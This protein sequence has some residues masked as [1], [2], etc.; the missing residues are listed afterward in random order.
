MARDKPVIAQN[1]FK[2]AAAYFER[3]LPYPGSKNAVAE[4][5]DL[6]W[7]LASQT[8][9][10]PP[11]DFWEGIGIPKELAPYVHVIMHL[12][13]IDLLSMASGVSQ[14]VCAM[15]YYKKLNRKAKV[16][17]DELLGDPRHFAGH[18]WLKLKRAAAEHHSLPYLNG[19]LDY[20][21]VETGGLSSSSEEDELMIN[22][23]S[24]P[25]IDHE[26]LDW[27]VIRTIRKDKARQLKLRRLRAF[28]FEN[29]S[30][31]PLS[32]I[33]DDL[34]ARIDDHQAA[35]KEWGLSTIQSTFSVS[36]TKGVM[37]ATA[38][39]LVAAISGQ[40]IPVAAAIGATAVLGPSTISILTSRRRFQLK[41][42]KDPISYIV[43]LKNNK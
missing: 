8:E 10:V 43:E 39:S 20:F 23:A 3:F 40:A 15:D 4:L 18:D 5:V 25:I 31:K 28:A 41:Q 12:S 14:A 36:A 24:V 17:F 38:A 2:L 22:I 32:F 13:Q 16:V 34:L 30:G 1:S 37:T 9:P 21:E 26:K 33:E 42:A 29:Y 27:S 11:Q 35:A 7:S 19:I 6:Q